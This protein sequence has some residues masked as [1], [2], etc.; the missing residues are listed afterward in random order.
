MNRPVALVTGSSR[1]IGAAIANILRARGIS[2]I[3]HASRAA[4]SDTIAADLADPPAPQHLWETALERA[5]GRI[6]GQQRRGV[7]R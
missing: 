3:G 7:R 4:D 2:V 5:G 1:G 6:D